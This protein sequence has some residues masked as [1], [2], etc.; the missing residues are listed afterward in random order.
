MLPEK[1]Q[2]Y[3]PD[4]SM[5]FD[6]RFF[7][8]GSALPLLLLVLA[9]T[10]GLLN[11]QK[12][13]ESR[14][15]NLDKVV[16]EPRIP[17]AEQE[18][19]ATASYDEQETHNTAES[20]EEAKNDVTKSLYYR[21]GNYV[22]P[23]VTAEGDTVFKE[24]SLSNVY[25]AADEMRRVDGK[26]AIIFID[27]GAYPALLRQAQKE[28]PN[29]FSYAFTPYI[30]DISAHIDPNYENW[31][32][33]LTQPEDFPY[34][35]RG[36]LALSNEQTQESWQAALEQSIGRTKNIVG[37]AGYPAAKFLTTDTSR[38]FTSAFLAKAGL[39][40]IHGDIA[41]D[42]VSK[43][44]SDIPMGQADLVIDSV[45]DQNDIALKLRALER[46][47]L[48]SGSAIAYAHLYPETIETLKKW[49]VDIGSRNIQLTTASQLVK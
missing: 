34:S 8:I 14:I 3:M 45:A 25:P 43:F 44:S 30:K 46:I 1:L 37:L 31:L 4:F 39:G 41:P 20:H 49:I 26:I 28:L 42:Q 33:F 22:L 7:V 27:A 12:V 36:P 6:L 11:T 47:A 16:I 38:E 32:M 2:Q 35:D 18:E 21:S 48:D 15:N 40:Y 10:T 17:L 29:V 19:I 9:F 13:I 24:F 23:R 5:R